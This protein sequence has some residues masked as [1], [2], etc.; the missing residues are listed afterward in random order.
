[1]L[2][3]FVLF[4][5]KTV[6]G[7]MCVCTKKK[8]FSSLFFFFAI[9]GNSFVSQKLGQV[10]LLLCDQIH[11]IFLESIIA[12]F[13]FS[14]LKGHVTTTQCDDDI[15][16]IYGCWCVVCMYKQCI[17]NYFMYDNSELINRP[18]FFFFFFILFFFFVAI[19]IILL[20][21]LLHVCRI[22]AS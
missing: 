11:S 6:N 15:H 12:F 20:L 21:A 14:I 4:K 10:I 8:V 19:H 17:Q 16:N 2:F 1:M 3:C 5:R 18:F 7:W 22:W 9:R 13:C